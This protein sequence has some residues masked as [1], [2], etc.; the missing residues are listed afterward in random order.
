[1]EI[2]DAFIQY[3]SSD[4]YYKMMTEELA[5]E[6]SYKIKVNRYINILNSMSIDYRDIL[7]TFES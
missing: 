6:Q 7:F 1:M 4:D 2:L 3:L 5:R